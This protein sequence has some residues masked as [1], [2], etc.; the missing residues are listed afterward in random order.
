MQRS[1]ASVIV[2]GD[3]VS[4]RRDP[5]DCLLAQGATMRT[6]TS[7]QQQSQ[8]RT[9][10]TIASNARRAGVGFVDARGWLCARARTWG[11]GYLCPLVINRTITFFDRGHISKT[12][13]LEL[14]Q[15]FRT[16]FRQELFR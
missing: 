5:V 12:Y 13:A 8:A 11:H 1:S 4:Q 9:E 15:V 2:V 6:C 10:R 3:P 14:A 16:A 7:R